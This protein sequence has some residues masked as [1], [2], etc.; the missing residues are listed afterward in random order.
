MDLLPKYYLD[1]KFMESI[2]KVLTLNIDTLRT[3]LE[4]VND[5]LFI[6]RA[7]KLLTRYEKAFKIETDI[8]LDIDSRIN[9]IKA[10]L[11]ALPVFNKETIKNIFSNFDVEVIEDNSNYSFKINLIS[12]NGFKEMGYLYKEVEELKPAHLNLSYINTSRTKEFININS[13]SIYAETI[14]VL[15]FSVKSIESNCE[16]NIGTSLISGE[17][18]EIKP[19]GEI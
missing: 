3:D 16:L 8:N 19:K 18:I 12:E 7:E 11:V 2:Q 14:S 9:R 5:E 13:F 1:N 15:P 4:K 6:I 10:K 17:S